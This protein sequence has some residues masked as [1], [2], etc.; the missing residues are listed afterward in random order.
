[1]RQILDTIHQVAFRRIINLHKSRKDRGSQTFNYNLLLAT[2]AESEDGNY[3]TWRDDFMQK[4]LR[5]GIGLGLLYFVSFL[6]LN[7]RDYLLSTRHPSEPLWLFT[8]I[9]RIISLLISLALMHS[10]VFHRRLSLIF[11]YASWSITLFQAISDTLQGTVKPSLFSWTMVFISQATLIPVRWPFHLLAQ[12]GT[13]A[14]YFGVNS[15]LGFEVIPKDMPPPNLFLNLFWIC[16]ICNLSVYLYERLARAE[17]QS[18]QKLKA[19]QER[20]ERLLLN[21]LPVSIA[22]RLKQGQS[23]IADSFTDVTVL[24]ADLV[25]FTELAEGTSP[26]ALV[27]L[28]NLIFSKFDQLAEQHRLE[29]I[30]TIGDAYLVVAGLPEPRIN[31]AVAVAQMALDM[32]QALHQVNQQT[33]RALALRIGIHTGPVVAGVIGLKK[34][35]YDLWGD[36][37]NTASRMESHGIPG[38]IQVTLATYDCLKEHYFFEEREP[39][40]VKGK[41]EMTT[42]LLQGKRDDFGNSSHN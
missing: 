37:V 3:E 41:G 30:K 28:L 2:Q 17:F 38:K 12:L 4:R 25:G 32:Q 36:T 21:I 31:H 39:I 18:R 14:Y 5:L 29:K 26:T 8:N 13:F 15:A 20:S 19:A 23:I 10:S 34:F 1:M 24:F 35:A 22:E 27:E 33:G 16:S 7:L 9:A 42:Y 40:F 11:L 6:P